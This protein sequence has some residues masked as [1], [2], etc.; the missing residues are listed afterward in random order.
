MSNWIN[1]L[2]VVYPIGSIYQ[3]TKSTS[4]SQLIGGAWKQ[5][6]KK[7]LFAAGENYACGQIGDEEEHTLSIEE[8]PRHFHKPS[9]TN[10][11]I[12]ANSTATAPSWGASYR[13]TSA[14]NTAYEG[15][16]ISQQH[17]ALL[18]HLYLGESFLVPEEVLSNDL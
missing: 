1:L 6:T 11:A 18:C 9:N 5:I 10:F 8:M 14:G 2:E 13:S 4:P 17:A 15:G 16:A 7:F 12:T 3:S